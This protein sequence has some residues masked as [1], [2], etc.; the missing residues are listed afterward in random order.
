MIN[1]TRKARQAVF[2][3][4]GL[5]EINLEA[6]MPTC[7]TAIRRL[8]YELNS[9]RQTGCKVLKII[10]GYGSTGTGGKIR[11]E[12]RTYLRRQKQKGIIKYIIEGEHFSIFDEATRNAFTECGEL[13]QDRD[14]DRYNNG[15]T[16]IVLK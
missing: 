4:S 7:D 2:T 14:L 13:R 9:G 15:I 16:I 3:T 6:G 1:Y 5:K 8:T 12:A 10:H 11:T